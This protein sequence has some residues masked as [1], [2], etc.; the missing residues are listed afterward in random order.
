MSQTSPFFRT[1]FLSGYF[2]RR[3]GNQ[4]EQLSW[5][6]RLQG[7]FEIRIPAFGCQLP[8]DLNLN[9]LLYR[10]CS[11]PSNCTS[12][13]GLF[14]FLLMARTPCMCAQH[15]AQFKCT[16]AQELLPSAI[17][18]SPPRLSDLCCKKKLSGDEMLAW[19]P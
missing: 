3:G 15:T 7:P 17:Y 19:Q 18:F 14:G 12:T 8:S 13:V 1:C 11:R 10:E 5:T 16:Q 4:T 9:T 6:L 2:Y